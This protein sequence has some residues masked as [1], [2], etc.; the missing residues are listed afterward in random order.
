[1]FLREFLLDTRKWLVPTEHSVG[2]NP[3]KLVYGTGPWCKMP[4]LKKGL[5]H[6]TNS[7]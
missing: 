1:M 2:W 3:L 4:A 6:M 5:S 7:S